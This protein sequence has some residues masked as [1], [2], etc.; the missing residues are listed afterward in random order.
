VTYDSTVFATPNATGPN[1]TGLYSLLSAARHEFGHAGGL[2][3]GLNINDLMYWNQ[4]HTD[5]PQTIM[6]DDQNGG[7]YILTN[8]DVYQVSTCFTAMKDTFAPAGCPTLAIQNGIADI[9]SNPFDVIIYPNPFEESITMRAD[10]SQQSEMKV[11]IFD[12]LGQIVVAN[13]FGIKSGLVEE[14]MPVSNLSAGIYVIQ[15]SIDNKTTQAKM[16]KK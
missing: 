14:S 13:D 10:L 11:S 2:Y 16:I 1:N 12:I 5:P 7:V 6:N 3:D 15:V 4:E 9:S 8:V